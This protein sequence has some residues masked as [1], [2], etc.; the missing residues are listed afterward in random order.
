MEITKSGPSL[1]K[2]REQERA[3][4]LDHL[5]IKAHPE[6]THGY[7]IEHHSSDNDMSPRQQEFRDRIEA[8]KHVA[9]HAG[10]VNEDEELRVGPKSSADEGE[11]G[12]ENYS[13]E[14][15]RG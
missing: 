11:P 5:R 13:G 3:N 9:V 2:T 4:S 8:L 14:E 6:A 1:K 10:M 7:V 15:S 12:G